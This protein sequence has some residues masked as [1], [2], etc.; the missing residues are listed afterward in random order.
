[1]RQAHTFS[2]Y[3]KNCNVI[4]YTT[5]KAAI[6]SFT[7]MPKYAREAA[8][9]R[10]SVYPITILHYDKCSCELAGFSANCSITLVESSLTIARSINCTSDLTCSIDSVLL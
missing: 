7:P 2:I 9:G 5:R 4:S 3:M 8:S 10:F 6:S 1:M